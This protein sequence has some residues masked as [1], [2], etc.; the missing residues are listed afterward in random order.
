MKANEF[1][2]V[3]IHNHLGGKG[4]DRTI[5]DLYDKACSFDMNEAKKLVDEAKDCDFELIALTQANRLPA[6]DYKLIKKY[7]NH[8]GV[9]ILPGVEIN[10]KNEENKY[11]HTVVVFD[12]KLNVD[13]IEKKIDGFISKNKSNHLEMNQFL[14]LII[15]YKCIIAAH[16]IKQSRAERSASTNPD[17]FSELI[18]ISDSIPV[19]IEDNHKYHKTTLMNQLRDKLTEK[20][21]E[22]IDQ[23]ATISTADR[24]SFRDVKSPTY[25][26]GNP[27]FDDLYYSCFMSDTRIK[28]ETDIIT[29]VNYISKI[30]ISNLNDTQIRPE[31]IICSHGLN[32]II[33][34]SGSGKTLL[35]DIIKRKLTGD[36]IDNKTI[37][38]NCKYD[39]IYNLSQIHL[40]D[41]DGKELDESSGY[42]IVEGEILYNKVISA[43]QSDKKTLLN[44]L[45]LNVDLTKVSPII[46]SFNNKLNEYIRNRITIINNRKEI[47]TLIQNIDSAEKFLIVNKGVSKDV[48]DYTKDNKLL[49]QI[50][51]LNEQIN[52]INTD[53]SSL[54]ISINNIYAIG[55]KYNANSI[56]YSDLK[57]IKTKLD[58]LIQK[59]LISLKLQVGDLEEILK[60]Q[61]VIFNSVLS[62]NDKIGSQFKAVSEKKQEILNNYNTILSDLLEN[63]KLINTLEIPVLDEAKIKKALQFD[64]KEIA[65]L[66]FKS[67]KLEIAKD[68]FKEYFPSNIGNK[69]KL[70]L[71][72]FSTNKLKLYDK[73]SV[74]AFAEVFINN[75]YDDRVEFVITNSNFIDYTIEL[76]NLDGRFENIDS[77]SAGNLSKI[78]INKMFEDKIIKAGSNTIVLYDQPD[79]NM[80]K[81]FILEELVSKLS[82]LRNTNQVFIT[83]HEPLLVVNADS[84]NIIVAKNDKTASKPNDISYSNKSFVGVNSK[85]E[86]ISDVA[87]LID[88]KPEAVQLRSTIYGGVLNES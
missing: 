79:T 36:G 71:S 9:C 5:D 70:K 29:K 66:T 86:L 55:N 4:A 63:V 8:M 38:K 25:I 34:A 50:Q 77:I 3:S 10:L 42:K 53:I 59:R 80:E 39:D 18:N 30:E 60:I 45:N 24:T 75:M 69:P 58:D 61:T 20:E 41:S 82:G 11:L 13:E 48:I 12:D 17:T 26:W 72:L 15:D 27:K 23:S 73:E 16:G 49:I 81:A 37:S 40:Y 65:R 28:R 62:Y 1:C 68:D 32:S 33:G 35:L 87:K 56:L 64:D 78:Y 22:W 84:N 46:L 31:T 14:E 19:V 2:K 85:K 6:K 52:S 76:K 74:S 83:T 47:N 51:T 21:L 57:F 67:V 88:G 44:E 43:Y 7:G 54:E